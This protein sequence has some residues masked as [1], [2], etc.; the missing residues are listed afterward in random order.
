MKMKV[1]AGFA[2]FVNTMLFATYYA[3]AKEAL[4]RIDPIVFTFFEMTTLAP[5]ALAMLAFTCQHITWAVV[6]RGMLLGSCLCLALFTIAI[7]LKYSTATGT[8][9]FPALNG[10]LAAFIA[11]LV[12]RQPINKATWVAGILS[13]AGTVLLIANSEMGGIRGAVIAFLGGLFFT[14]YVFLSDYGS[15]AWE[16]QKTSAHWSLLGV[17]L[18]TMALWASL[19]AL[20]FGDWQA[21][22]PSFP[23]DGFIILYIALACTFLPTLVSILMQKHISAVSVS[24]IYVLEPVLGVVVAFFYLHEVLP[25]AGYLGGSL[26]VVG[27]FIHTWGSVERPMRKTV[28][29]QHISST[30]PFLSTL[31]SAYLSPLLYCC[32]GFLILYGL[33]G[34]PP[35][36]WRE[37]FPLVPVLLNWLHPGHSAAASAVLNA[38]LQGPQRQ[39]FLLQLVLAFGWLV[40]WSTFAVFVCIT[41]YHVLTCGNAIRY[42]KSNIHLNRGDDSHEG[43]I[44]PLAPV[45]PS[46]E[47]MREYLGIYASDA[48]ST[49]TKNL[50]YSNAIWGGPLTYTTVEQSNDWNQDISKGTPR[51][52]FMPEDIVFDA[53]YGIKDVITD[54]LPPIVPILSMPSLWGS[55]ENHQLTTHV[56]LV[57]YAE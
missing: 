42:E 22:H 35:L 8:A 45:M 9:F 16:K 13:V 11:W 41:L 32:S 29:K 4:S 19:I 24:F 34:F 18:L 40:G 1:I 51:F 46:T 36:V 14:L 30:Q 28:R 21:F 5:I 57:E 31:F 33:G 6:K 39:S 47:P 55:E 23:K 54:S 56:N 43:S 7:A 3:V 50:V 25:F 37:L 17:E 52:H 15:K 49:D 12:L 53:Q 10:F 38:L 2:F 20:L 44:T 27:A 48:A 26:V